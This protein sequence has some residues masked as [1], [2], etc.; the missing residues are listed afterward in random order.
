MMVMA[1]KKDDVKTIHEGT[2]ETTG[3]INTMPVMLYAA[4]GGAISDTSVIREFMLRRFIRK[5]FQLKSGIDT[6]SIL[7]LI[8][9]VT[10]NTAIQQDTSGNSLRFNILNRTDGTALLVQ[11]DSARIQGGVPGKVA[12][13]NIHLKIRQNPPPYACTYF[14]LAGGS[15]TL[16]YAHPQWSVINNGDDLTLPMIN[17]YFVSYSNDF[18]CIR[19]SNYLPDFF[20][21]TM[22]SELQATDTLLVQTSTLTLQRK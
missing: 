5:G 4:N 12:C 10:G 3:T 6:T 17:Y 14:E 9:T 8:L 15:A 1:C 16:C 13:G 7:K 11:Q 22:L 20:N 18:Y 19:G 2:Y 21:N